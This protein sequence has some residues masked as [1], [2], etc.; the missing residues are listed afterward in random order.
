[1]PLIFG[2]TV[3]R[4]LEKIMT[5][6][7]V[8]V[9]GYLSLIAV[10]MVSWPVIRDVCTGF[11][12][13]GILPVAAPVDQSWIRISRWKNDGSVPVVSRSAEPGST[14]ASRPAIFRQ[15]RDEAAL[16]TTSAATADMPADVKAVATSCCT[17]P[18]PRR[19]ATRFFVE[20][21]DAGT[22]AQ[23]RGRDHRPSPLE[24]GMPDRSQTHGRTQHYTD[25]QT[26]RSRMLRGSATCCD[27]EG[28]EYVGLVG[29]WRDH[30]RLP[31]LDWAMVVAFIGIAGAGGLTNTLFSNY[32]RDKGWGMGC[33]GRR[34]PQR[35]RRPDDRPVAHRRRVCARRART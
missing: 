10:T 14:M 15:R 2:G 12:R 30:G 23:G 28:V 24:A 16:R 3:Y 35:D 26:C 34:D 6:K 22:H 19:A 21:G 31:A 29:Y 7:L 9:L 20:T 32:A 11:L 33:E 5:A 17:R 1:M 8:L 4:M 25:L 18:G 27:H 13:F